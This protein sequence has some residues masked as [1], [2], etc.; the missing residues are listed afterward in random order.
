M[1]KPLAT[2]VDS[3]PQTPQEYHLLPKE[4]IQIEVQSFKK[5]LAVTEADVQRIEEETRG[6]R[7]SFKWFQFRRFRITAS[8]FG[9]VRRRR[10]TTQPEA[11]VL[12]MLG[13][14]TCNRK[15]SAAMV[16]GRSNES[17]ALEKYKQKKL[18]SSHEH[19]VVTQSG[20]WV[21]YEHPFLGASPD[22]AVCDPSESH[23]CGFVEIKCPYKHRYNTIKEACADPTFCCGLELCDGR[24]ELK[25]KHTHL[26][27]SQVQGQMAI[28]CRMWCDFVIYTTKEISVERIYF[29]KVFWSSEL[30]PKLVRFYDN[31]FAPEILHPMHAIGLPVRDLCKE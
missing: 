31:C 24:E 12:R 8:Y 10:E 30:L 5:S 6:Q 27:Y 28:G 14:N 17:L 23:P 16:W 26:Y 29:D 3:A 7:E 13:L 22:A 25:L 20:L 9:E 18:A 2:D 21:S 4:E 15:E 1:W 11:L 19:V